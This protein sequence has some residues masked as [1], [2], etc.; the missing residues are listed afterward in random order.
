MITHK[1][2]SSADSYGQQNT[3]MESTIT[4][5]NHIVVQRIPYQTHLAVIQKFY[6]RSGYRPFVH[7]LSFGGKEE[8]QQIQKQSP[9]TTVNCDLFGSFVSYWENADFDNIGEEYDQFIRLHVSAVKAE[10][11]NV[12]RRRLSPITPKLTRVE[13]NV[14][15]RGS[16]RQFTTVFAK[17]CW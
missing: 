8:S 7:D 12:T 16:N 5:K 13:S 6:V 1:S 17:Q 2:R 10:I 11:A 3:P 15:T 14:E 9:K 4:K